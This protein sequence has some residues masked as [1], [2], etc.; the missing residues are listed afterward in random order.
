MKP[1]VVLASLLLLSCR[2]LPAQETND[3]ANEWYHKGVIFELRG[4]KDAAFKALSS[5]LEADPQH[6]LARSARAMLMAFAGK[7]NEAHDEIKIISTADKRIGL[8]EEAR[9]YVY[10]KRFDD[11]I[12]AARQAIALNPIEPDGYSC[13]ASIYHS[14]QNFSEA[15]KCRTRAIE[16]APHGAS[17]ML[18]LARAR[19]YRCAGGYAA[20]IGDLNIAIKLAQDESTELSELASKHYPPFDEPFFLERALCHMDDKQ[21]DA[22]VSDLSYLIQKTPNAAPLYLMRSRAHEALG[23][24]DRAAG[25]RDKAMQLNPNVE[26]VAK[27]MSGC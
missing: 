17:Q 14:K 23:D 7:L 18:H 15:I 13:L 16:L 9:L 21:F 25:D 22:A 5:A 10:E 4:E 11:A 6:H 19:E 12:D 1:A 24:L 8:L 3:V 27:A 26:L 2:S 20:A